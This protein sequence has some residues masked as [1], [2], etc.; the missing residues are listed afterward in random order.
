MGSRPPK[1]PWW[2][3]VCIEACR[4]HVSF[5][6]HHWW[7]C[8]RTSG[9]TTNRTLRN[10]SHNRDGAACVIAVARVRVRGAVAVLAS[11]AFGRFC[12]GR[13]HVDHR[14]FPR[15]A[16]DDSGSLPPH[17]LRERQV[18]SISVA[19]AVN[20]TVAVLLFP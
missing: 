2:V 6:Q 1:P 3:V 19:F 8:A 5:E 9:R 20:V 15:G 14:S 16:R 13:L 18:G 17:E 12:S 7:D 11:V 10:S 4:N